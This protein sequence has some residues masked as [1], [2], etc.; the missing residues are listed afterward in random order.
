MQSFRE[1]VNVDQSDY[2]KDGEIRINLNGV[3][4]KGD[5]QF[6]RLLFH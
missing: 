1:F 3:Q 6:F 2:M 5:R 4:R